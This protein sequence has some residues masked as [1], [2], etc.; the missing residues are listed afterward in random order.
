MAWPFK[1]DGLLSLSRSLNHAEFVCKD[2]QG[3]KRNI[4]LQREVLW[5]PTEE[6]LGQGVAALP[7][8]CADRIQIVS[9]DSDQK[10]KANPHRNIQ[11]KGLHFS[12]IKLKEH[13]REVVQL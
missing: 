13:L 6:Y 7:I 3:C 10:N 12:E 9:E 4:I 1:N 2:E 5:P 11:R 8:T